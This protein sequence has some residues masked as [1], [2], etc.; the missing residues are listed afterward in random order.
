[1]GNT[2]LRR[3]VFLGMVCFALGF[4]MPTESQAGFHQCLVVKITN[5][6]NGNVILQVT[7]A[8]GEPPFTDDPSRVTLRMDHLSFK[9]MYAT[10][11]TAVSM[12]WAIEV[13]TNSI[14]SWTTQPV[15]S[16]G[17]VPQY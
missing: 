14:P 9:N 17:L 11:L 2:A 7:P 4:A 12:G 3:V 5:S 6:T 13:Q 8:P 16:L 1:M 15:V 10:V